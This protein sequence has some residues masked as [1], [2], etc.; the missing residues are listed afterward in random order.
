MKKI[1]LSLLMLMPCYITS[2]EI[3]IFENNQLYSNIS[4]LFHFRAVSG[5]YEKTVNHY[6]FRAE[7]NRSIAEDL[8]N[9]ADVMASLI[10]EIDGKQKLRTLI[11]STI[12]SSQIPDIK[13][14]ILGV[15]LAILSEIAADLGIGYYENF[16][17]LRKTLAMSA[18]YLECSAYYYRMALAAPIYT[19]VWTEN[20]NKY[21]AYL[22]NVAHYLI[23]LDMFTLTI[24]SNPEAKSISVYI[25]SIREK[26][27]SE[28]VE[29][30]KIISVHSFDVE[31]LKENL[32]EI[33]SECHAIDRPLCQEIHRILKEIRWY[34]R[35]CEKELGLR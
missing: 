21:G 30:G 28:F 35:C 10:P 32:P 6:V 27:L 12:M 34:L 33:M 5:D 20:L 24:N 17:E 3:D 2:S 31:Y 7:L 11:T 26:I 8:L 22:E 14:K 1:L 25:T 18:T 4:D 16:F 19:Q 15:G 13:Y 29:H 9:Q 23:L